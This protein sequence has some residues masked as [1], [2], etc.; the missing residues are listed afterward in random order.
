MAVPVVTCTDCITALYNTQASQVALYVSIWNDSGQPLEIE[1]SVLVGN[2]Q[3]YTPQYVAVGSAIKAI[4]PQQGQALVG[5]MNQWGEL[6]CLAGGNST[7][8]TLGFNAMNALLKADVV[9]FAYRTEDARLNQ[10]NA[11]RLNE[12]FRLLQHLR[13]LSSDASVLAK[14]MSDIYQ[15]IEDGRARAD[16]AAAYFSTRI[17]DATDSSGNSVWSNVWQKVTKE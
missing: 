16:A 1:Q 17:V 10:I 2:L 7:D 5:N 14:S 8:R 4:V 11:R 9:T 6:M 12:R 15:S 3:F 13:G